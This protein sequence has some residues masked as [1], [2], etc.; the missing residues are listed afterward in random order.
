[1][2]THYRLARRGT[3]LAAMA[4]RGW[5]VGW[6]TRG[7]GQRTSLAVIRLGAGRVIIFGSGLYSLEDEAAEDIA[8]L[9]LSGVDQSPPLAAGALTVPA[10]GVRRLQLQLPADQVP[11]TVRVLL[12]DKVSVTFQRTLQLTS[13]PLAPPGATGPP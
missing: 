7:K 1:V 13:R 5:D 8:R 2:G 4:G 10:G 12:Y 9:L 3:L 11:A 6:D